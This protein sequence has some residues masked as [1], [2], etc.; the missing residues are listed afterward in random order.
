[1]EVIKS[2]NNT[3]KNKNQVRIQGNCSGCPSN[4]IFLWK[5]M[6]KQFEKIVFYS[7]RYLH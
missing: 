1:M 6:F 7:I 3:N 4:H 2:N 5:I